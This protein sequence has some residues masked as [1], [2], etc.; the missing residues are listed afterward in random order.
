MNLYKYLFL[1]LSGAQE[2]LLWQDYFSN[3][4]INVSDYHDFVTEHVKGRL[5]VL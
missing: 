2:M 1:N 4:F 5:T 3:L